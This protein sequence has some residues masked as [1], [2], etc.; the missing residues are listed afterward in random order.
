MCRQR[1]SKRR[2]SADPG[3]A[4]RRHL[5]SPAP[6]AAPVSGPA[7]PVGVNLD[8]HRGG[9]PMVARSARRVEAAGYATAWAWDHFV[10]RGR[11]DDPVLE[12]WTTL[13]ATAATTRR[14]RVGSFVSNVM[15]RHPAVLAR[16]VATVADLAPGRVELG[17]GIGGH[18]A[19]HTAYGI[20]FPPPPERAA[21]LEEAV[22]VI[23]ALFTGGPVSFHGA[24]YGLDGADAR[25]SRTR[26]RASSSGVRR[27]PERG[28]RHAS[29]MAGPASPTGTTRCGRCSRLRSRLPGGPE[30]MWPSSSAVTCPGGMQHAPLRRWSM[31]ARGQTAGASGRA[32]ARAP[33]IP[34]QLEAGAGGRGTGLGVG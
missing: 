1:S 32:D 6:E 11:L 9:R 7:I 24:W 25:R 13:A 8:D 16:V 30:T 34:D 29:A 12:C 2:R 10:S 21:R 31:P 5:R 23:R 33:L 15:N 14:I 22:T 27:L 3:G 18:P 20:E 17:I 19:E 4:R 28:S 26:C